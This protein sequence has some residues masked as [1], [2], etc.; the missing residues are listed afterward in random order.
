MHASPYV[1]PCP[2]KDHNS[3]L[4]RL[5]DSEWSFQ[6][7]RL[8]GLTQQKYLHGPCWLHSA[9][10][11]AAVK[12]WLQ[13]VAWTIPGNCAEYGRIL[14]NWTT[15]DTT[16]TVISFLQQRQKSS[17]KLSYYCILRFVY[18]RKNP[19]YTE[20]CLLKQLQWEK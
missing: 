4:Y 3:I 7:H 15:H 6:Y 11:E 13:S 1:N 18:V 12:S 8:N 2:F 19:K 17:G 5:L 9:Y 16:S 20:E 10:I 14:Q